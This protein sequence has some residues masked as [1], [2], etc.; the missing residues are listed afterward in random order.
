[1]GSLFGADMPDNSAQEK[2]L[3][4][5]EVDVKKKETQQAKE[6]ASRRKLAGRG[7]SSKTL[8]SQVLGTDDS[9]GKKAKLGG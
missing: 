7:S 2:R 4:E 9:I 3:D 5:Q 6:L 8:F 1:M